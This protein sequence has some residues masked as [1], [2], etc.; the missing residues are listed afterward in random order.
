MSVRPTAFLAIAVRFGLRE[1]G[2][3]S[4]SHIEPETCRSGHDDAI[5]IQH[6][7]VRHAS[8]SWHRYRSCATIAP[9]V[10]GLTS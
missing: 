2:H 3:G 7:L 4:L 9:W 8:E 5:G 1:G 6:S 10:G